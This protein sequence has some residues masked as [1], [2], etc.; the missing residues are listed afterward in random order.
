MMDSD[1]DQIY[2]EIAPGVLRY[3]RR[4]TGSRSLAEDILQ[5]T[6]IKLHRQIEA[7]VTIANVRAWLFQVATN[8]SKDEK[9][10]EIRS[11]VREE[12]YS[13]RSANVVV[14]FHW[15]LENQQIVRRTLVRLTPRMR[16]VLLLFSEGFSYREIAEISGVEP[17]YVGV[18]MQRGRAAFK[19]FYEEEYGQDRGE[20][21]SNSM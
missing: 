19:K 2:N 12:K 9:R 15:Q 7:G 14:D 18:L 3:L 11:A 6:F 5:E 10:G 20:Q 8:L 16:Q 13:A 17:T 1:F 21:L 4:F